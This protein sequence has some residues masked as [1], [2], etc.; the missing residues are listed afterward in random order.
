MI[1]H[2]LIGEEFAIEEPKRKILGEDFGK[3]DG[4][5][6]ISRGAKKLLGGIVIAA[7]ELFCASEM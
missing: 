5:V 6:N 3:A 7:I 2:H 4:V 1:E